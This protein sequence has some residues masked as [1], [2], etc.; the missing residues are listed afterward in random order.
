MKFNCITCN[1]STDVHCNYQKHSNSKKHKQKVEEVN[2]ET[3]ARLELTKTLTPRNEYQCPCCENLY[4]SQTSLSRH[5]KTCMVSK[6]NEKEKDLLI[7]EGVRVYTVRDSNRGFLVNYVKDDILNSAREKA[8]KEE[9][10]KR[11]ETAKE[12]RL[13]D[14]F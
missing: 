2:K 5:K 13:E 8:K 12:L 9:E 7:K 11:Q 4:N 6:D 14:L 10:M 1:Y 3:Q